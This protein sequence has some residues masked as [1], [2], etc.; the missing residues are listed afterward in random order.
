MEQTTEPQTTQPQT[1]QPQTIQPQTIQ[2][3]TTEHSTE[4]NLTENNTKTEDKK[5]SENTPPGVDKLERPDTNKQDFSN[6]RI[7]RWNDAWEI[8][9]SSILFG[10]SPRGICEFAQKHNPTTTMALYYYSISNVYLELL[11][12]TGIIGFAIIMLLLFRVALNYLNNLLT[13]RFNKKFAL[14]SCCTLFFLCVIFLQSDLFFNFTFGGCVF[15]LFFGIC[16]SSLIFNQ[17]E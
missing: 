17:N 7:R 3:Q 13:Q 1:P 16:N 2:P 5:S 6:G 11:A 8:F 4:F 10:A 15:W 14:T 12:E 9:K